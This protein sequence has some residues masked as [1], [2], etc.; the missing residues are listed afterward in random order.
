ME[1]NNTPTPMFDLNRVYDLIYHHVRKII[2]FTSFST[3][4]ILIYV[5]V[6]TPLYTSSVSLYP[7]SELGPSNSMLGNLGSLAESFG[8]SSLSQTPTYNLE[9]L[10]HSRRL[11]K[12]I[13]KRKWYDSEISDSTNLISFWEIDNDKFLS[14]K[15]ILSIFKSKSNYDI[16]PKKVNF[17]RA[18]E[19][20]DERIEIKDNISGLIDVKVTMENPYLSFEIANYI[21]SRIQSFID[22][23]QK[24]QALENRI[25]IEQQL[26]DSKRGLS[27]S[28][29]KLMSFRKMYPIV[30]DT[31][32]L[33]L[34]RARLVRDIEVNQQVYITL[35]QQYELA[36][37][38]ELKNRLLIVLLDQ[39]DVP[40]EKS[41]PKRLLLVIISIF[42]S[43]IFSSLYIIIRFY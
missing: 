3:L 27:L 43:I 37:I 17:E 9:D 4:L 31:P 11:K 22:K 16:S 20:L 8:I 21:V 41:Y 6:V 40:V 25:F 7:S 36:K 23:E 24:K 26:N 28:E 42:F 39:A 1:N 35:R 34:D 10:L 13:I 30:L 15:K 18:I 14:F 19:K 32:E 5:M 33:Q 29:K 12:D 38:E 2:V